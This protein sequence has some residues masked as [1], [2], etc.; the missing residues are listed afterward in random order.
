MVPSSQHFEEPLSS[1]KYGSKHLTT[2]VSVVI[3]RKEQKIFFEIDETIMS[4]WNAD[5]YGNIKLVQ[6]SITHFSEINRS[7]SMQLWK[8]QWENRQQILPNQTQIG[9]KRKKIAVVNNDEQNDN[10]HQ[11]GFWDGSLFDMT[12]YYLNRLQLFFCLLIVCVCVT[13]CFFHLF[14]LFPLNPVQTLK[15]RLWLFERNPNRSVDGWRRQ[16]GREWEKLIIWRQLSF[17]STIFHN[18]IFLFVFIFASILLRGYF[19]LKFLWCKQQW[20][21][22]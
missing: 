3:F 14:L 22:L 7:E 1:T 4:C 12:N 8:W 19:V 9:E 21:M 20:K 16:R 17:S 6:H 5:C 2:I 13:M 18:F 15:C 10:R 11:Y